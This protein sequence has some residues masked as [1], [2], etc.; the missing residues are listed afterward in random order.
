MFKDIVPICPS[1]NAQITIKH[2]LTEC[3]NYIEQRQEYGLS[4]H[5]DDTQGD[6]YNK[7]HKLFKF[8][9]INKICLTLLV[10]SVISLFVKRFN[11]ILF[12][13]Y[14]IFH[15]L[16]QKNNS[17][18]I[19]YLY[20]IAIYSFSAWVLRGHLFQESLRASHCSLG[21]PGLLLISCREY[22]SS[23]NP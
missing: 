1:C 12:L 10:S 17:I 13:I 18:F 16:K 6:N 3:L 14:L 2:I 23:Q 4:E 7:I 11:N 20:L 22:S 19:K 9:E 8:L 21:S 15:N 5:L